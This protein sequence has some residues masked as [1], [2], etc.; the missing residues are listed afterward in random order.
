MDNNARN[1]LVPF[2]RDRKSDFASGS[3]ADLLRSKV[4]QAIMTRGT[5]PR[6][7]GE[8][9]WRTA[10]G[11]GLDLL[12]HQRNDHVLAELARIYIRDT[13][14]KWVPEVELIGV[15]PVRNDAII[16]IQVRFRP[17]RGSH[18][19]EPLTVNFEL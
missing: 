3:G 2:R 6:S 4:L 5:T 9:P 19:T 1:L 17:S 15:T 16:N 13:L 11:A 7:S 12:R 8:L 14:S 10:F 18:G